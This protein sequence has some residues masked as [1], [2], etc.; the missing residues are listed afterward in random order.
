[1]LHNHLYQETSV[2][3]FQDCFLLTAGV[4]LLTMLPALYIRSRRDA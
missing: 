1:M 4:Y 2:A 3:A